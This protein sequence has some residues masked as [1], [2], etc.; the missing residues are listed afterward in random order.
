MIINQCSDQGAYRK[1]PRK[2]LVKDQSTRPMQLNTK[3]GNEIH[4]GWLILTTS[5]AAGSNKQHATRKW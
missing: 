2:L 1:R 5:W 3:N 4:E